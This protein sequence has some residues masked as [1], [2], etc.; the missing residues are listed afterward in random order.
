[1]GERGVP[2]G[3]F[4]PGRYTLVIF[5][6]REEKARSGSYLSKKRY[7]VSS[8]LSFK[9]STAVKGPVGKDARDRGLRPHGEPKLGLLFQLKERS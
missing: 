5:T 6:P 2:G 8:I 9:S 1:M 3:P 4:Y 7:P